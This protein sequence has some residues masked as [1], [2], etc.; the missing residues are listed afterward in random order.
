[1]TYETVTFSLPVRSPFS[2]NL[3]VWALRRRKTNIVDRWDGAR[4]SRII[5]FN[6][7]PVNITV[8][9]EDM[10]P[11]TGIR[12]TLESKSV[13]P[14]QIQNDVGLLL[15]KMLGLTIDLQPFYGIAGTNDILK[16]LVARFSGVR[17]PRFPSIFEA[18]INSIACQQV[19]LD[20]GIVML[21]RL[22]ES[23]G[24]NYVD[25]DSASQAFPRPEDL[26]EVSEEEI[27]KLGFSYQ[28]AKA[29]KNLAEAVIDK[30]IELGNLEYMKNNE[31]AACLSAIRGIGR[32]SA[33]YVLLRGL[34]RLDSFPGDDIGAQNNLKRIF[35]LDTK[36]GYE[37]IKTLTTQWHPYE[38]LVYFHLLL[39]K[40][41]L[42]GVI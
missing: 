23:F 39:E 1:M 32:W 3:T 41:H 20:A 38:G 37:E 16:P 42:K 10:S 26:R 2:L 21:N 5:V 22:S 25:N 29:I 6:S 31:A 18:L 17:P 7:S 8:R 27:R 9:Q 15:Q 30:K 14:H 33:E 19:S 34:G 13:L 35:H 40:L 4:Y 12:I 24:M 11:E 28:K 36:P